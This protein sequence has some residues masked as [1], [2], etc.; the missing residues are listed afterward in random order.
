MRR[1]TNRVFGILQ[2]VSRLS[3]LMVS[4]VGVATAV[5]MGSEGAFGQN[6]KARR[7]CPPGRQVINFPCG[8]DPE[9]T[10]GYLEMITELLMPAGERKVWRCKCSGLQPERLPLN[11]N[12]MYCSKLG[13]E[14]NTPEEC[15]YW[16]PDKKIQVANGGRPDPDE[17][18][19][20]NEWCTE[21]KK[22]EAETSVRCC[23]KVEL[24]ACTGNM[25]EWTNEFGVRVK[26]PQSVGRDENS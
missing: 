4:C 17:W 2:R 12:T 26:C 18:R 10:G 22:G 11:D 8:E 14:D 23:I 15:H 13:R 1:S 24:F 20:C 21:Q 16:Y 19:K 7:D 25:K 9:I 6:K 5:V 3:V